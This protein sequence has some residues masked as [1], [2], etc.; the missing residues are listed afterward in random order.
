M[1][2]HQPGVSDFDLDGGWL[3]PGLLRVSKGAIGKLVALKRASSDRQSRDIVGVTF[4]ER[5]TSTDARGH[6]VEHG[7][8]FEV[9]VWRSS[10][11]PDQALHFLDG[12][13][14]VFQIPS[15]MVMAT[16]YRILD[17]DDQSSFGFVLR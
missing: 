16:R 12:K 15:S 3:R 17:L 1:A 11:V 6:S 4:I 13:A 5:R 10:D 14:F 8:G 7:P 9:G 2:L